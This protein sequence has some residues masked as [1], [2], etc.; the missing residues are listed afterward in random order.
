MIESSH[1][2]LSKLPTL[3]FNCG[4]IHKTFIILIISSTQFSYVKCMRIFGQQ[5][6][7]ICKT[8]TLYPSDNCLFTT[9]P[10]FW[11]SPFNFLLLNLTTLDTS[12]KCNH[13]VFVFLG[14]AYFIQH[15]IS[16]VHPC[17]DV[18]EFSLFILFYYLFIYF[19]L[20]FCHFLDHSRGIWRFPG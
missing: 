1:F 2:S 14:L 20:S 3:F 13:T 8:K 4:Q 17:L 12:Y 10:R 11:P 15:N 6:S 5:V 7:R 19:F 9:H 16:K 18:S